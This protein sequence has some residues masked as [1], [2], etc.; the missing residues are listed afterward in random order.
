MALVIVAHIA[1]FTIY[2][3]SYW[4]NLQNV[5][6]EQ[7]RKSGTAELKQGLIQ[8]VEQLETSLAHHSVEGIIA[9]FFPL[10]L[11]LALWQIHPL[12]M[13]ASAYPSGFCSLEYA[14][15]ATLFQEDQLAYSTT[16]A[17]LNAAIHAFIRCLPMM[18]VY[19]QDSRRFKLFITQ[20]QAYK[21]LIEKIIIR[22]A[23]A[24]SVLAH[25]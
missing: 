13:L 20:Q 8:D 17:K 10:F 7:L 16:I 9:L 4:N 14:S 23:P 12:L 15:S 11:A 3:A 19:Q 21:S 1:L 22:A 2:A 5:P 18:R 25:V 24:W 6:L